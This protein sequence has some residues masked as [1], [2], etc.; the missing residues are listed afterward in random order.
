MFGGKL[1]TFQSKAALGMPGV[2]YVVPFEGIGLAA[3]L[4]VAVVADHYWQ[5]RQALATLEPSVGQRA[6]TP[7]ARFRWHS[8]AACP[9]RS[10]AT[11]A[12]SR[13]ARWAMA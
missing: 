9:A 1:K 4:G 6:R 13:T 5:A 2:R 7:Q 8:A 12:A 3:R 10:T 11:R